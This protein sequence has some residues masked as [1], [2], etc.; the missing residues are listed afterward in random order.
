MMQSFRELI[1]K[2]SLLSEETPDGA[3]VLKRDGK[4]KT[5]SKEEAVEVRNKWLMEDLGEE[6]K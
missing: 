6:T 1:E 3:I 5:Y 2:M 4:V